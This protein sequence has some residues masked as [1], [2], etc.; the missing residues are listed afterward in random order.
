ME[1]MPREMMKDLVLPHK[2]LIDVARWCAES[3]SDDLTVRRAAEEKFTTSLASPGYGIAL[4]ALI[5]SKS[6]D[7]DI[8]DRIH[9]SIRFKNLLIC[10]WPK[11]SAAADGPTHQMCAA[12]RAVIKS[13]IVGICV[14]APSDVQPQVSHALAVVSASCLLSEWDPAPLPPIFSCLSTAL[15]RFDFKTAKC[16]LVTAASLMYRFRNASEP[17][18][19]CD[20]VSCRQSFADPL[21]DGFLAVCNH[22]RT[23]NLATSFQPVLECLRLFCEIFHSL[24]LTA[25]SSPDSASKSYMSKWTVELYKFLTTSYPVPEEANVTLCYLRTSV[26]DILQGFMANKCEDQFEGCLDRYV[27]IVE[28]LIIAQDDRTPSGQLTVSALRFLTMVVERKKHSIF[29]NSDALKRVFSCIIVPNLLLRDEDVQLF[30]EDWVEYIKR[31]KDGNAGN[32]TQKAVWQL[33]YAHVNEAN[34]Q[35]LALV[36][37]LV[38]Q[39]IDAYTGH[40]DKDWRII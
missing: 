38:Q 9:A 29:N 28:G 22:L 4:L 8:K 3:R 10:R 16:L 36:L 18:D 7:I 2:R 25:I 1:M 17:A 35:V 37:A 20:L 40:S 21:L 34:E 12:D 15:S 5:A 14:A 39:M 32:T 6:Q 31:D 19:K 30:K 26:C 23:V 24:Y 11:P 27:G 33:L 13:R